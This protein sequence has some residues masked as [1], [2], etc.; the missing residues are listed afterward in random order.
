MSKDD[1]GYPWDIHGISM[2]I[3]YVMLCNPIYKY[4]TDLIV[5]D[6]HGYFFNHI[7]LGYHF[8]MVIQRRMD[9]SMKRGMEKSNALG[10]MVEKP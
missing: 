8:L 10:W 2:D 4:Y 6:I 1:I 5:G 9:Q 3:Q 7:F